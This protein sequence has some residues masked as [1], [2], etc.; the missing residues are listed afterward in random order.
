MALAL[1]VVAA[2]VWGPPPVL[3]QGTGTVRYV[4]LPQAQRIAVIDGLVKQGAHAQAQWLL[5]NSYFDEGELGY[6]AALLQAQVFRA[7]GRPG[8]A[9]ALLRR[10][11]AERPDYRLVRVELAGL[12][13]ETGRRRAALHHLRSLSDSAADPGERATFE[14]LIDRVE[15]DRPVRVSGFLGLLGDS[16]INSGTDARVI[17]LLGLPFAINEGARRNSGRGLRFGATVIA[18]QGVGPATRAYAAGRVTFDEYEGRAFD[19]RVVDLRFGLKHRTAR[20]QLGAELLFDRGWWGGAGHDRAGG[21]RL[22][23]RHA[24]RP[25]L[26]FAAELEG[27]TR[28][29]D[30]LPAA[31]REVRRAELRLERHFGAE[32]Q[33]WIELGFGRETVEARPHTGFDQRRLELGGQTD[34]PGGFSTRLRLARTWEEY[35]ADFPGRAAARSDRRDELSVSLWKRDLSVAGFSPRL[36]V[37]GIRQ[38]SNV[39]LYAYDRVETA[40]TFTRGF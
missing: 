15:S 19:R 10:I 14:N 6:V 12:M 39:V 35:H 21:L 7:T 29:Y 37:T 5:S 24:L 34:L 31:T 4:D 33:A 22:T 23:A 18:E 38:H 36:T 1:A 25:R 27:L 17:R 26:I 30:G 40:V 16:N 28:R 3:A 20:G 2:L 32:R 8:Q 9:E 11:L 13:A